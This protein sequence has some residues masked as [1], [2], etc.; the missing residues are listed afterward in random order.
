[1]RVRC[2]RCGGEYAIGED[3]PRCGAPMGAC[4]AC[5]REGPKGWPCGY[6]GY[7]TEAG[8]VEEEPLNACGSLPGCQRCVGPCRR[9][10]AG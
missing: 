4:E 5:G 1:M 8:P 6:C 2:H 9:G 10:A 7:D 3:C